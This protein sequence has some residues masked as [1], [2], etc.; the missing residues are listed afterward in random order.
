MEMNQDM[1]PRD[2]VLWMNGALDLLDET[3]PTQEQWNKLRAKLTEQVGTIIAERINAASAMSAI[4]MTAKSANTGYSHSGQ[5]T[6]TA[7]TPTL[8]D[9]SDSA[10]AEYFAKVQAWQAK[11]AVYE[12]SIREEDALVNRKISIK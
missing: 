9:P 8:Q 6:G 7:A 10:I 1:N 11:E 4:D 3:P 5:L 12:A 2:F